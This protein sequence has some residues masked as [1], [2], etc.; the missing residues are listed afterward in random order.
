MGRLSLGTFLEEGRFRP[1]DVLCPLLVGS[2]HALDGFLAHSGRC[3]ASERET[4]RSR[5][6]AVLVAA[7]PLAFISPNWPAVGKA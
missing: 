5:V 7:I 2:E 1:L 4:G 3:D 6:V